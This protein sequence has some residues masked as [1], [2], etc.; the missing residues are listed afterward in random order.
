[1]MQKIYVLGILA[2]REKHCPAS[3]IDTGLQWWCNDMGLKLEVDLHVFDLN[4]HCSNTH[5]TAANNA[6][7]ENSFERKAA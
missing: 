7:Y 4:I 2:S 3:R 6:N 5:T 1:M